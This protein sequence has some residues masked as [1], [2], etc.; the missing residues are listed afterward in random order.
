MDSKKKL[1]KIIFIVLASCLVAEVILRLAIPFEIAF[2]TWFPRGMHAPDPKFG[3]VHTPNFVGFTRH[4]DNANKV[5]LS[6]NEYGFRVSS[7]PGSLTDERKSL[8]IIGAQSAGFGYGLPDEMI[9]GGQIAKHSSYPMTVYTTSWPGFELRRNFLMYASTMGKDAKPDLAII[10]LLLEGQETFFQYPEDPLAPMQPKGDKDSLFQYFDDLVRG[11]SGPMARFLGSHYYSSYVIGRSAKIIDRTIDY[12]KRFIKKSVFAIKK[13]K[14]IWA[15]FGFD[16][17]NKLIEQHR[18][19]PKQT[20]TKISNKEKEG[21]AKFAEVMSAYKK[22]FEQRGAQMLVVFISNHYDKYRNRKSVSD[23]MYDKPPLGMELPP[24]I[25]V[26]NLKKH[27]F[28]PSLQKGEDIKANYIYSAP[29][30]YYI[31]DGHYGP[32][33]TSVMGRMIAIETDKLLRQE[34]KRKQIR[35]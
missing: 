32:R 22:Y 2:D 11:P 7:S 24:E 28:L 25:N 16:D 10:F 8:V 12:Y 27:E 23:N 33:I 14:N 30:G 34:E 35:E 21:S 29:K 20:K 13:I 17:A 31:A 5:L 15:T 19:P 6:Q 18:T 26:L 3:F 9:I 1:S 4:R